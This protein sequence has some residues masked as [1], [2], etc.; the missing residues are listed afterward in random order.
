MDNPD[1]HEVGLRL[2]AVLRKLGADSVNGM[3]RMTKLPR[4][5]LSNWLNGYSLPKIALVRELTLRLPGLT[6]EWVYF[7]DDRLM[8]AKLGREL[9]IFVEAFRQQLEL[10]EVEQESEDSVAGGGSAPR[11]QAERAV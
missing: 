3:A 1:P 2:P 9:S 4:N 10:W 6:L 8:P 11:T 7:G 5:V